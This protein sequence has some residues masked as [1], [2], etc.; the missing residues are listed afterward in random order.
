MLHSAGASSTAFEVCPK[1]GSTPSYLVAAPSVE[2]IRRFL[3]L[4]SSVSKTD[5]GFVCACVCVCLLSCRMRLYWG[6]VFLLFAGKVCLCKNIPD[7]GVPLCWLKQ[8]S[9][10]GWYMR[11]RFGGENA[12]WGQ[13]HVCSPWNS[14]FKSGVKLWLEASGKMS[15]M[16]VGL[17]LSLQCPGFSSHDLIHEPRRVCCL[18]SSPFWLAYEYST[19]IAMRTHHLINTRAVTIEGSCC[20]QHQSRTKCAL[21]RDPNITD[22][23]MRMFWLCFQIF[24]TKADLMLHSQQVHKQDPKPYKC[25]TCHKCFA[26]SSYMSQHNR[27]HAGIKPFHCKI[28]ERKFTQQVHLQQH[29]R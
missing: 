7:T 15:D 10:S 14:I 29:M 21:C 19:Y 12:S 5:P 27:I 17:W 24:E 25:P 26:N 4:Q 6:I 2:V 28:C 3:L 8:E 11:G 1:M 22:V 13:F 23:V 9:H 18:R 20:I 16:L